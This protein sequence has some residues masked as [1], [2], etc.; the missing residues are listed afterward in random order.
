MERNNLSR[1]QLAI[2]LST[3]EGRKTRNGLQR[4]IDCFNY[5]ASASRRL[6]LFKSHMGEWL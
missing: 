6:M 2:Y 5:D 1:I 3:Q 4:K